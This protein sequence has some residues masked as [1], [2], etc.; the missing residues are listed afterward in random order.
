MQELFK[1][2]DATE[3]IGKSDLDFFPAEE[4]RRSLEDEQ[5]V[6]ASGEAIVGKIKKKD[7]CLTAA[8]L[9]PNT[10]NH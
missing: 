9:G 2:R 8:V 6:L 3:V 5:Q 10:K 4:A 1:V 7:N